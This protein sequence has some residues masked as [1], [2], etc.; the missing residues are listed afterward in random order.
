MAQSPVALV[1]LRNE[2]YRENFHRTVLILF[3]SVLVNLGLAGFL[4]YVITHPPKPVYFPTSINGRITPLTPLSDPY[5]TDAEILQWATQAAIA[6]YSYNFVNY[7]KEIQAASEF[8]TP[9]GW[10][11]FVNALKSS[12][13]LDA[14]KRKR[15]IVSAVATK[16]P[17]ITS[18]GRYSGGKYAGRYAWVIKLPLL[19]TY[20]GAK[21]FSQRENMVTM[22]IVRISTLNSPSGVG[23]ENVVFEPV[24]GKT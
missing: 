18:R 9:S 10:T 16:A 14:V 12:N 3:L 4:F 6:T 22:T 1:A 23:I 11:K 8:F 13:N 15:M 2:Y 19:V 21:E 20:Q 24:S 5:K 17:I 7:R